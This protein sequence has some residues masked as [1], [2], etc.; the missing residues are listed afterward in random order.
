[1]QKNALFRAKNEFFFKKCL[2][3]EYFLVTLQAYSEKGTNNSHY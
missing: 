1:M 3:Y 2:Q